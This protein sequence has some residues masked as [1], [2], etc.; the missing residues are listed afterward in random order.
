MLLV[1]LLLVLLPQGQRY[2]LLLAATPNS[3]LRRTRPSR[4]KR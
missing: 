4:T 2:I 3:A 1:L